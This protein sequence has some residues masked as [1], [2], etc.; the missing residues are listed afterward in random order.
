MPRIN[1]ARER[2][3]REATSGVLTEVQGRAQE[4]MINARFS[5]ALRYVADQR[6]R[7]E[8]TGLDRVR[9]N[10]L[11]SAREH[12]AAQREKAQLALPEYA[13]AGGFG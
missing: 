4:Y 12:W 5:D 13:R 9:S 1:T 7:F 11:D 2:L 6:G 10:I 3:N 8:K